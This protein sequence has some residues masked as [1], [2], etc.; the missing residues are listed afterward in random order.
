[1]EIKKCLLSDITDD[2]DFLEL[3]DG[4]AAES[5]MTGLPSPRA[6]LEAY[7]ILEKSG[8]MHL[9]SARVAGNL[10]GFINVLLY[11]LP[12]Y[13]EQVAVTESFFVA[14]N[15]RKSGAGLG[16]LRAVEEFSANTR[17]LGLLVSAP[18]G[19]I[20]EKV[21]PNKGYNETSRVFF[22]RFTHE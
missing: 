5:A 1:M 2:K 7:A 22:K 19:G 9:F 3:L 14:P 18:V 10:V 11:V 16:L 8:S 15:A 6:K 13:S 20:L 17:A 4:Y 21:L 12:H